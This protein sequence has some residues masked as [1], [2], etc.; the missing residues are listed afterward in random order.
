MKFHEVVLLIS[1]LYAILKL[2]MEIRKDRKNKKK[3]KNG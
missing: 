1:D 3:E 2:V